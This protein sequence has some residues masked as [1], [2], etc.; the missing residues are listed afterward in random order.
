[1]S[2]AGLSLLPW[3]YGINVQLDL[4]AGARRERATETR[5]RVGEQSTKDSCACNHSFTT[6]IPDTVCAAE[7]SLAGLLEPQQ[8]QCTT[9][10]LDTVMESSSMAGV[11]DMSPP[12]GSCM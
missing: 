6:T 9:T 2:L 8:Y 11:E 10:S 12:Y 7:T 1:M 4:K 3:N 5:R